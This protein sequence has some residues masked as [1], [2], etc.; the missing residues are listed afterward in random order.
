MSA[1][2]AWKPECIHH[3]FFHFLLQCDS[4]QFILCLLFLWY[5]IYMTMSCDNNVMQGV[6]WIFMITNV[7]Q[8]HVTAGVSPGW[9]IIIVALRHSFYWDERSRLFILSTFINWHKSL[10]S[11]YYKYRI[12]PSILCSKWETYLV[13]NC[14]QLHLQSCLRWNTYF[15]CIT[16]QNSNRSPNI[17]FLF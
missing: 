17:Y 8:T 4:S 10:C 9:L 2:S 13:I 1:A 12:S 3:I 16:K 15:R 5:Y 7:R 6:G 11:T 14:D